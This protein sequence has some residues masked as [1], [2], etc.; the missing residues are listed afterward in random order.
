MRF[1]AE[2][3]LCGTTVWAP[4]TVER[5]AVALADGR[6]TQEAVDELDLEYVPV[7]PADLSPADMAVRAARRALS[8]SGTPGG[9]IGLLLHCCIWHQGYDMWSAP[10]FIANE[11]GARSVLP[12]TMSQGCNAVM[13]ALEL[14]AS[15][16]LA[17]DSLEAAM[18]TAAD[19]FVLPGFDRWTGSY[20]C[21]HGDAATATVI[22]RGAHPGQGLLLRSVRS[23]AVPELEE[24]NRA[25]LELTPAPRWNMENL[26]LRGT[27]KAYLQKHGF[28]TFEK[29]AKG[30]IVSALEGAF[31]DADVD[32]ADPRVKAV[33]MPRMSR[34]IVR[35]TYFPVI[36][37][38][39]PAPPL[40]LAR[41]TGH[42]SCSDILANIA[43]M[44]E[45]AGGPLTAPGDIGVVVNAGG[46]YT[47]SA[48][49]LEVPGA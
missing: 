15:R 9:D 37:E 27:K 1:T 2:L 35:G 40:G 22:K 33:T 24:M 49:V 36:A 41:H 20:A 44:S 4:D 12:A 29:L 23:V 14:A 32:P 31:A 48:L 11:I 46:G 45:P 7:A 16:L 21:A 8:L 17:D 25:G 42:L 43:D 39:T 6:L 10:H 3:S 38:V 30:A 34:K 13:P 28:E 26:D 19:R 5:P 47:W 18:I